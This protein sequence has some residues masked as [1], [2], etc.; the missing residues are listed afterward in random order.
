M[1]AHIC[2]LTWIPV[3]KGKVKDK[4]Y[5][6]QGKSARSIR[7]FHLDHEWRKE[8]FRTREPA[9]YRKIYQTN[10]RVN[11]TKTYQLFVVPIGDEKITENI[12]FHPATPVI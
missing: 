6:F 5:N 7:W 11:D 1:W 2:A 9:F 8:N 3:K 12:V 4:K 10:I